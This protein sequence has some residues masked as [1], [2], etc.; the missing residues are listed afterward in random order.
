M[1]CIHFDFTNFD[2]SSAKTNIIPQKSQI[3]INR[4]KKSKA[5][6]TGRLAKTFFALEIR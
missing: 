5:T 6:F 2:F 1:R 3:S 4:H